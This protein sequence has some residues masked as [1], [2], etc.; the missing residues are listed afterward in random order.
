MWD[1]YLDPENAAYIPKWDAF[2]K[3]QQ[4]KGVEVK[5]LHT[6]GHAYV[7]TIA[8]LFK[9][10]NPKIIIPM[11]TEHPNDFLSVPEFAPYHDRVQVLR[12]GVRFSLDGLL[13]K[14]SGRNGV[15]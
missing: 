15:G 13:E 8:G 7:E 14:T 10:V 1:G 12:D 5:R 4:A 9:L 3:R 2:L 11:H 6:S